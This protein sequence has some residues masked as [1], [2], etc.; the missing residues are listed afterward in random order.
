MNGVKQERM[1]LG[2]SQTQL[3]A[4]VGVSARHIAFIESEDRKPSFDVAARIAGVL[5]KT[6]DE[7][8]L[9]SK[10][11]ESTHVVSEDDEL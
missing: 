2:I 5:G 1:K 6:V 3:A 11:T 10:C 9:P 8:F 4:K 7:I